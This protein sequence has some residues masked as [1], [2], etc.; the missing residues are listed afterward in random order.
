[1]DQEQARERLE[2]ATQTVDHLLARYGE[3]PAAASDG[4]WLK[5]IAAQARELVR[6]ASDYLD[7]D[8]APQQTP[9]AAVPAL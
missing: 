6:A 1:M 7:C 2:I 5:L 9:R 8:H 4:E 3:K